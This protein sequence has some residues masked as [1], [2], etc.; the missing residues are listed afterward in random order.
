[1][2]LVGDLYATD[3]VKPEE[4]RKTCKTKSAETLRLD[5]IPPA[6]ERNSAEKKPP[7]NLRP[8]NSFSGVAGAYAV[9]RLVVSEIVKMR[10]EWREEKGALLAR[11]KAKASPSVR[12]YEAVMYNVSSRKSLE[13]SVLMNCRTKTASHAE[14][15][16]DAVNASSSNPAHR[17]NGDDGLCCAGSGAYRGNAR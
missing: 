4:I 7:Q 3:D 13:F 17:L 10:C 6:F 16:E 14:H 9:R 11:V 12:V 5:V 2:P 8:A 15:M 1:M